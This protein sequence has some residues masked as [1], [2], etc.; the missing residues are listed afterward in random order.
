MQSSWAL[1]PLNLGSWVVP[2]CSFNFDNHPDIGK[3]GT[4]I[5]KGLLGGLET[6]KPEPWALTPKAETLTENQNPRP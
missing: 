2:F 4:L 6:L 1:D 5:M 3:K